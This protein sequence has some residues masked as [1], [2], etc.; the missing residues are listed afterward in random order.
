MQDNAHFS[1]NQIKFIDWLAM[2]KYAR[3]PST[4]VEF[5]ESIGVNQ[6]TLVRWKKGQNGFTK[7][8][9]WEAVTKRARDMNYEHLSTV[10]ESLRLEAEKGSFQ[11]QKLLL[12]LTGEYT[13]KKQFELSGPMVNLNE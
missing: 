10:Y 9:F 12:E 6:A 11:H 2:G 1:A 4:Q 13:E 7:E 3:S 5:A 8:Q